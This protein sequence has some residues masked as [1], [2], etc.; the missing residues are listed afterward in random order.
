[1][2]QRT[3]ALDIP[4]RE[5]FDLSA[6]DRV[7]A[8]LNLDLSKSFRK[9]GHPLISSK[10]SFQGPRGLVCS[11]LGPGTFIS[12]LHAGKCVALLNTIEEL[13]NEPIPRVT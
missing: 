7:S 10:R 12:G 5:V 13:C 3:T 9:V 8:H 1:M 6:R 11:L 4:L 2:G